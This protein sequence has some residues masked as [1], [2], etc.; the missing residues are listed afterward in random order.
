[1]GLGD[2]RFRKDIKTTKKERR[3]GRRKGTM[4]QSSRGELNSRQTTR[5]TDGR[6]L[7]IE[8]KQTGCH[9]MAG[10][11]DRQTDTD[12]KM[13]WLDMDGPRDRWTGGRAFTHADTLMPSVMS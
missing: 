4:L 8:R 5:R 10:Q 13:R 9:F 3:E 2:L 11:I 12:R 1:M 6:T 7:C